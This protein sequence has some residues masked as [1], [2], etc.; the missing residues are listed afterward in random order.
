MVVVNLSDRAADGAIWLPW[1][2]LGGK[3]W[4]LEDSLANEAFERDVSQM[5]TAGLC[6]GLPPWGCYLLQ[7]QTSGSEHL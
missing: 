1:D 7:F 2:D 6:V 5:E 3:Q 4:L